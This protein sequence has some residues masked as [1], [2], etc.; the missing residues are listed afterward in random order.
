MYTG[1]M[2]KCP[3]GYYTDDSGKLIPGATGTPLP[4]LN[5]EKFGYK[6]YK[7]LLLEPTVGFIKK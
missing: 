7:A 3:G 1:I 5:V 6:V 2:G 4:D